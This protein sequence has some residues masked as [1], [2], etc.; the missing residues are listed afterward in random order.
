M[1]CRICGRGAC[2]ESLHSLRDLEKLDKA[3]KL[4][5]KYDSLRLA[6]MIV[7]LEQELEEK[8]SEIDWLKGQ[9]SDMA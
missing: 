1:F 3:E 6:T 5:K 9:I 7:E 8:N 4:D 2:T